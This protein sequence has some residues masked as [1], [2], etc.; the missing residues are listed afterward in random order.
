VNRGV[1]V[2]LTR[3]VN[4]FRLRTPDIACSLRTGTADGVVTLFPLFDVQ[5]LLRHFF[6]LLKLKMTA[7]R[8]QG[9]AASTAFAD[10]G[11]N[12]TEKLPPCYERTL[13]KRE[14][15]VVPIPVGMR[16]Q[17]RRSPLQINNPNL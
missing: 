11:Q 17:I 8:K 5:F 1:R 14:Q 7:T 9:G 6:N 15:V 4:S 13:H 3:S 10:V 16:A 2:N 12:G